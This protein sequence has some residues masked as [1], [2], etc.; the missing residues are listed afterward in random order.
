MACVI[1]SD[2]IKSRNDIKNNLN[3][4]FKKCL[5]SKCKTIESSDFSVKIISPEKRKLNKKQLNM[6]V[7]WRENILGLTYFTDSKSTFLNS[8]IILQYFI[9]RKISGDKEEL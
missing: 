7:N 9:Y 8:K 6:K 5:E 2:H 3:G 4:I 1:N